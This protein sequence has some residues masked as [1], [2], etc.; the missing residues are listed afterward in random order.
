MQTDDERP[1]KEN[2]ML[3]VLALLTR[4]VIFDY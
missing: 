3:I 2:H 1:P 4:D